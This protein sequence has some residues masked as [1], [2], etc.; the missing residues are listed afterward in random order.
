[1]NDPIVLVDSSRGAWGV[2][3][4]AESLFGMAHTVDLA[5]GQPVVDQDA[6]APLEALNWRLHQLGGARPDGTT[7][8]RWSMQVVVDPTVL[9]PPRGPED[10]PLQGDN[11]SALNRST[12]EVDAEGRS[13]IPSTLRR[14]VDAHVGGHSLAL[15]IGNV[16]ALHVLPPDAR[17]VEDFS[18]YAALQRGTDDFGG[19]IVD[20]DATV[21]RSDS[22]DE[23]GGYVWT[24]RA[25]GRVG[26]LQTVFA[27]ELAAGTLR[28]GSE[29]TPIG[30]LPI[31][32][33]AQF[34]MPAMGGSTHLVG[35]VAFEPAK[36]PPRRGSPFSGALQF[37]PGLDP[38]RDRT[39]V[40]RPV[41]FVDTDLPPGEAPEPLGGGAVQP[42]PPFGGIPP[43]GGLGGSGPGAGSGPGSGG[44]GSGGGGDGDGEEGSGGGKPKPPKPPKPMEYLG[45]LGPIDTLF[46]PPEGGVYFGPYLGPVSAS[47]PDP[48]APVG[49][50]GGGP[51]LGAGLT[52]SPAPGG[53]TLVTGPSADLFPPSAGPRSDNTRSP[54]LASGGWHPPTAPTLESPFVED[55]LA[56]KFGGGPLV[57]AGDPPL[58]SACGPTPD[59]R[60][61]PPIQETHGSLNGGVVSIGGHPGVSQSGG[62]L[63]VNAEDYAFTLGSSGPDYPAGRHNV[64]TATA[65][66]LQAGGNLA[67]LTDHVRYTDVMLEAYRQVLVGLLGGVGSYGGTLSVL[68]RNTPSQGPSA[69]NLIGEF[70]TAGADKTLDATGAGA[71][72]IR[73]IL[74]APAGA[75]VS[76]PAGAVAMFVREQ[77]GQG[78][79]QDQRPLILLDN[80]RGARG[81]VSADMLAT[82]D[83]SVA[84]TGAGVG[85][86]AGVYGLGTNPQQTVLATGYRAGLGGIQGLPTFAVTAE[87]VITLTT[88]SDTP[89]APS[90]EGDVVLY[91]NAGT[92]TVLESDGTSTAL[93]AGGGGGV[94]S[95]EDLDNVHSSA[96]GPSDGSVL[97]F[98]TSSGEWT[99]TLS[100]TFSSLEITGKL[101]VG[102]LIDPTGLQ[103][104]PQASSPAV[105][106]IWVDSADDRLKFTWDGFGVRDVAFSDEVASDPTTTRGDIIYRNASGNLARLGRGNIDGN[107]VLA[108]QVDP[109]WIYP[110]F[111]YGAF[112]LTSGFNGQ[113]A[114]QQFAAPASGTGQTYTLPTSSGTLA[115]TSDLGSGHTV[116]DAN[117]SSQVELVELVH[118]LSS[119]VPAAGFGGYLAIKSGST[120]IGEFGCEFS[121][122]TVNC[123]LTWGVY[124][125]STSVSER[126][127]YAGG[128]RALRIFDSL[129]IREHTSAP[130]AP[131]QYQSAD[132]GRFAVY[133]DRPHFRHS[134]TSG[135]TGWKD[136]AALA[137]DQGVAKGD[138]LYRNVAGEW[139]EALAI[140]TTGQVLTVS[141][142]GVPEWAAASG[143][144]SGD[145]LADGTVPLTADWDVGAFTITALRFVSDQATGTAPFSVASTTT[146]SNLSADLLDGQEGTYYLT[147][148]NH[149]GTL[150]LD[151][152]GTGAT[153]D[154]GARTALGLEIGTDV[155]AY[156]AQLADFAGLT[157]AKG[158]V[159]SFDGANVVKLGVGSNGQILYAN[160]ATSSGLEWA[161]AP[162][163]DLL[164]DGSVP[165]TANWDVGAFTLTALRF[166]SDQSTGTAPFTVASTTTVTNLSADLLDGQEGAYYL[167]LGN[168]TGTLAVANG[169]TG[170]TTAAGAR[171]ALGVAIGSDVQAYSALLADVAGLTLSK[172]DV[173][174]YNGTNLTRLAVG[175]NGQLLYAN[176][177]TATGLE[178]AAAPSG[179]S[180]DLLADGTV[181]LTANWDVGAFTITALRF[182]S[183]EAT[184]APFTV[185]SSALVT[186]LN[187]D[188]LDS[189]EGS[190][191]LT[192]SNH[193][194]TLAL[195]QGGTG[196]TTAAGA[197][198]ALGL[199]IGTDVQAYDAQLGDFAGLTFAKG[200]V[201][202][203]NGT[204]VVK[205]AV[206]TDGQVLKAN[207]AT[208]SGLEWGTGSSTTTYDDGASGL[209]IQNTS[210]ATKQVQFDLSGIGTGDTITLGLNDQGLVDDGAWTIAL[211]EYLPFSFTG[212]PEDTMGI[213][214]QG[215]RMGLSTGP[216]ATGST[217]SIVLYATHSPWVAMPDGIGGIWRLYYNDQPSMSVAA[218]ADGVYDIFITAS[219]G[220]VGLHSTAWTNDTTRATGLEDS[221]SDPITSRNQTDYIVESGDED[222][223]YIATI[224]VES[225]TVT[226]DVGKRHIWNMFNRR[227][228]V[229]RQEYSAFNY[230][231]VSSN[232]W[233]AVASSTTPGAGWRH[234]YVIGFGGA[235]EIK[236]Y[237]SALTRSNTAGSTNVLSMGITL[238]GTGAPPTNTDSC[239]LFQYPA[240]MGTDHQGVF[241]RTL[242][243]PTIGAHYL[244]AV[245][246]IPSGYAVG[247]GFTVYHNASNV[248]TSH[249]TVEGWW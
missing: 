245:E 97:Q 13:T 151:Q 107:Q 216:Y 168:A 150:A 88:P 9:D 226:N 161:A 203:Y 58:T 191:Y 32:Y 92:L 176:S 175:T 53:G 42:P 4:G 71:V 16:P 87:G 122:G 124:L 132:A 34:G 139:L 143:G 38:A 214:G 65:P 85:M 249:F 84:I 197:R 1:M 46:W 148:S 208:S 234:S 162:A 166:V 105:D 22:R 47:G 173:L 26:L 41:V 141:S 221:D 183:D 101:T 138:I 36:A 155:Q 102:G 243:E 199:V 79:I 182:A 230:H 27:P 121:G 153:T 144:G 195:D 93:G 205:L 156:D 129:D 112:G 130:A 248:R 119:G 80:D 59:A 77:R 133:Q 152:G 240:Y 7:D 50:G 52:V 18:A 131:S 17:D 159:F 104:T 219:G 55:A 111:N 83:R 69:R 14:I 213:S 103:L 179:G 75:A 239:C 233:A 67:T 181:P 136:G 244:Q 74:E 223:V 231:T 167:G 201:F 51:L 28:I 23:L 209:T 31:R 211:E 224:K 126:M 196:A 54:G 220:G 128:E 90:N 6:V 187:A 70:L 186:N 169:G 113:A 237:G 123:D 117:T 21:T 140:G 246:V 56:A 94:S 60:P 229:D 62:R 236:A 25:G 184:L 57:A 142:G 163:G 108:S 76:A 120:P 242:A 217:S 135:L 147:R 37:E 89:D 212:S 206:G 200:D 110:S 190:Y 207:S 232:S 180:G 247:T 134:N 39:G 96:S 40:W 215:C 241:E 2:G 78:L 225:G 20:L 158:D 8:R 174:A 116:T 204:N 178:W 165:L 11:Y 194:G 10:S 125:N 218:Y 45:P 72:E 12:R 64:F 66:F 177:A 228:Y 63:V 98:V 188:L 99:P 73:S 100:P 5:T 235:E 19:S 210:D 127:R 115:L 81:L 15:V 109:I 118:D 35:P 193:T 198:T 49:L 68:S 146:V 29:D 171:T 145:L 33:D 114:E 86:L 61:V 149:T 189:Q 172:G 24:Q 202:T 82:P 43:A 227:K 192:R 154:S 44:A 157:F 48:F 170:S 30:R 238:D 137:A 160:S 3:Y 91:N 185:A 164:A 222:D 95:I 106:T